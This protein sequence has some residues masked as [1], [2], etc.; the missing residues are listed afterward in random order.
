MVRLRAGG[1][2]SDWRGR[3]AGTGSLMS[4]GW[5]GQHSEHPQAGEW[6]LPGKVGCTGFSESHGPVLQ[7]LLLRG[8]T[9][10]GWG[11]S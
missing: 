7:G 6:N 3:C 4:S 9:P 1:L 2:A 5:Q 8:P 10:R 11:I